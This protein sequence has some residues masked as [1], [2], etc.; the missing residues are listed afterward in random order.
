MSL[1]ELMVGIAVGMFIVAAAATLV[2]TQ[3]TDNRRLMLEV[4]VQ[5]DLRATADIITRDIRRIGAT[6]P[7]SIT[8]TDT[9]VWS[10]STGVGI[11]RTF[12]QFLVFNTSEIQF[13]SPRQA[14]QIGPYGYKLVTSETAK[15]IQSSLPSVSQW[16]ALTDSDAMEVTDFSLTLVEEPP[17]TLACPKLCSNVG[18]DKSCWPTIT[19]RSVVV[20]ITGRAKSD[21]SV[22]KRVRSVARLRNDIVAFNVE[23]SNPNLSCPP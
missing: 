12:N 16:Q 13:N 10:E 8:D 19:V 2:A 6:G 11:D 21:H 22:V 3:L 18:I 17:I 15:V 20:D 23:V 14:G 1:V 7:V 5:Q 4:Q 9:G